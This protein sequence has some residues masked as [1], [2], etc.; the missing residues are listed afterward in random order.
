MSVSAGREVFNGKWLEAVFTYSQ[1]LFWEH[2]QQLALMT[3]MET[4]ASVCGVGDTADFH[5]ERER[6]RER[7]R[8]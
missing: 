1:Q 4:Y 2:S 3:E 5:P 7:E 8:E 6:E